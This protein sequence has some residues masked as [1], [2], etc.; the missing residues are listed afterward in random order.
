MMTGIL[1]WLS[2]CSVCQSAFAGERSLAQ[3]AQTKN[4]KMQ[5]LR[6]TFCGLCFAVDLASKHWARTYLSAAHSLP[7]IPGLLRLSLV[8]NTGAAFSLGSGHAILMTVIAAL[9]T[10]CLIIW[11]LKEEKKARVSRA[12]VN[13]GAGF[14]IGGALGNLSDRFLR[15]R[16]TDFLEFDFIQFP[17]FNVADVCIDIGVGLLLIS[18]WRNKS[19]CKPAASGE[20]EATV[21]ANV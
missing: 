3:P 5:M 16:V 21:D 1:F 13:I 2:A 6:L 8:S 14:L 19:E 15:G 11:V 9:V 12:L 4:G 17:V 20:L 10:L 7:F 18:A